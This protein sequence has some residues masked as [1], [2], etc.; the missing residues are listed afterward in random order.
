MATVGVAANVV[1]F[2]GVV[3][4]WMVGMGWPITLTLYLLLVSTLVL[5]LLSFAF[6]PGAF[7]VMGLVL[8]GGALV[9]GCSWVWDLG[10]GLGTKLTL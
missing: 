7:L 4:V 9:L 2:T 8:W 5:L 6:G 10:L 1:E 3:G